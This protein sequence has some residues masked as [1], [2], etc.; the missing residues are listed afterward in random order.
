MSPN[1]KRTPSSS[2]LM[3]RCDSSVK[4]EV[5]VDAKTTTSQELEME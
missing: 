4:A 2:A 5:R 3:I 1:R